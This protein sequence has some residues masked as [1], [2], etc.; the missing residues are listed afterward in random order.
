MFPRAWFVLIEG[1]GIDIPAS[2]SGGNL[3][4]FYTHAYVLAA[5]AARAS[6]L[7]VRF[8]RKAWKLNS[9]AEANTL[10]GDPE[11]RV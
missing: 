8:C 1:R 4:G 9:Y 5:N 11:W 2:D 10:E 7:G 6:E 3:I